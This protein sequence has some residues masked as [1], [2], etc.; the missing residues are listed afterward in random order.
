MKREA[1]GYIQ[2]SRARKWDVTIRRV[3]LVETVLVKLVAQLATG[4][5]LGGEILHVGALNRFRGEVQAR[6]PHLSDNTRAVVLAHHEAVWKLFGGTS[7][8]V[9]EDHKI[10]RGG[11]AHGFVGESPKVGEE[12]I[13]VELKEEKEEDENA[14]EE[15]EKGEG[16]G[17][18]RFAN[19]AHR[20]EAEA[21]TCEFQLRR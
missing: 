3:L 20:A 21:A 14:E 10:P 8:A 7:I 17:V 13:L 2:D 11:R 12:A 6:R 9:S 4:I 5:L 1:E 15:K 16:E 18:E 19:R